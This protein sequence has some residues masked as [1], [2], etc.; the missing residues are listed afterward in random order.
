MMQLAFKELP[1]EE[2]KPE[3]RKKE[4]ITSWSNTRVALIDSVQFIRR[5][6]FGL[7]SYDALEIYFPDD[8]RC[9]DLHAFHGRKTRVTIE[10]ID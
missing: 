6:F 2:T 8:I 7:G 4:F 3:V 5:A 9:M 1:M 10:I